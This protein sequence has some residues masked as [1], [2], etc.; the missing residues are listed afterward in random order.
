[1]SRSSGKDTQLNLKRETLKVSLH[2]QNMCVY[3]SRPCE[4]SRSPV[5]ERSLAYGISSR[6]PFRASNETGSFVHITKQDDHVLFRIRNLFLIYFSRKRDSNHVSLSDSIRVIVDYQ[7]LF[8]IVCPRSRR[9]IYYIP[10]RWY[11]PKGE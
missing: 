10:C 2:A 9:A 1:M 11:W 8:D 3:I 5:W 4:R 6:I 7:S